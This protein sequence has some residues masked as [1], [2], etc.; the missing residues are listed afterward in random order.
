VRPLRRLERSGMGV[1]TAVGAAVVGI[2]CVGVGRDERLVL[3]L[4]LAL[5]AAAV[6]A[7]L[8]GAASAGFKPP[9]L[10]PGCCVGCFCP[11]CFRKFHRPP[12]LLLS[13][14]LLLCFLL[15]LIPV[16]CAFNAMFTN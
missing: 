7:V 9:L 5:P 13:D 2:F 4:A 10:L 3:A 6:A 15:F 8:E 14:M 16:L 1:G 12:G 11:A